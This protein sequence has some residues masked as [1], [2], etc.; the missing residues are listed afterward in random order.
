MHSLDGAKSLDDYA[1]DAFREPA[2]LYAPD[3]P[4]DP[5]KGLIFRDRNI[6]TVMA[7]DIMRARP[8]FVGLSSDFEY[9]EDIERDLLAADIVTFERLANTE[10]LP[11][12]FIFYGMPL[13]IRA[14][15][16]SPVRAFAV[17]S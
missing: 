6:D 2:V 13:N 7:G 9:D 17:V 14:T 11:D 16:G 3:Q 15:D 1:L 4:I 8:C 12:E 10:R 5:G